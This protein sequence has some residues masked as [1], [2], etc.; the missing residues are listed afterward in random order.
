M[1]LRQNLQ[2]LRGGLLGPR[3]TR[4]TAETSAAMSFLEKS[5]LIAGLIARRIVCY[6]QPGDVLAPGE[7]IGYI[8][9]GSR[10]DVYLPLRAKIQVKLGDRL[11]GGETVIASLD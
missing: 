9:F 1:S 5:R 4:K 3:H 10:V 2:L 6:K 7:R 11:K 8:K